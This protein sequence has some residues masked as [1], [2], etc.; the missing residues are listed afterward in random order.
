MVDE[1]GAYMKMYG[2]LGGR[3]LVGSGVGV[4]WGDVGEW[5]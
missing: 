4:T 2:S 5:G 1:G 3:E